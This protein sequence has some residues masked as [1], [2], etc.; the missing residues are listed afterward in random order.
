MSNNNK[1]IQKF[2]CAFFVGHSDSCAALDERICREKWCPF[3]RT[4]KEYEKICNTDFLYES[5]KKGHI[6]KER[7]MELAELYHFHGS[8]KKVAQ[9]LKKYGIE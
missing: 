2:E 1:I 9:M 4:H 5:Y 8:K 3:F 6:D 7:L